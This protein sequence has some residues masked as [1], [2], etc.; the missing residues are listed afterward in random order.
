MPEAAAC[1]RSVMFL[2]LLRWRLRRQMRLYNAFRSSRGTVMLRLASNMTCS[3]WSSIFFFFTL[4]SSAVVRS[5]SAA[6]IQQLFQMPIFAIACISQWG[7]GF[8][9][10]I[11][12]GP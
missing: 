5:C 3:S 11:H 8:Q 4:H 9:C 1:W 2:S 6:S 12:L 7:S 10:F